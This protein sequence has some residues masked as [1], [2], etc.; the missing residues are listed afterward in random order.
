MAL[1]F[2]AEQTR[3]LIT[4]L[5]YFIN[6]LSWHVCITQ[7]LN[8]CALLTLWCLLTGVSVWS[9]QWGGWR[10]CW[11]AVCQV[12]TRQSYLLSVWRHRL[13]TAGRYSSEFTK[14]KHKLEFR[15]YLRV[16]STCA[17]RA[18][19]PL[20][21]PL[22]QLQTL[23]KNC[24]VPVKIENLVYLFVEKLCKRFHKLLNFLK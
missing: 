20:N 8:L 11:T 3:D 24:L 22:R 12:W 13:C 1:K 2:H 10:A 19:A 23:K 18:A 9:E 4:L 21:H 14:A 6:S 7:L 16:F 5:Q 17:T 15:N